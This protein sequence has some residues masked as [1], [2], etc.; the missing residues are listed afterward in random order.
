MKSSG[1]L[2]VAGLFA[3]ACPNVIAQ[4]GVA[5]SDPSQP[6]AGA[7]AIASPVPPAYPQDASPPSMPSSGGYRPQTQSGSGDEGPVRLE[8][9]PRPGRGA[10]PPPA[11]M[12]KLAA[13]TENGVTYL[14]GGI[15]QDEAN[16]MKQAARDYDLM[17]T[18]A[19]RDGSYLADVNV[20]IADAQDKSLLKTSCNAPIM[21]IDLGKSGIY[22]VR[23]E[24][25]GNTV[26]KSVQVK[27]REQGKSVV[28]VWPLDTV[29]GLAEERPQP[30]LREQ[31][32]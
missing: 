6:A 2:I 5:Q 12:S 19:A 25:G 26:S 4:S 23:A 20:D 1:V 22:R 11:P 28:L 21:L 29:R 14:C 3:C 8:A 13:R 16:D 10:M 17:L 15:G 9:R 32:R 30:A 27:P 7:A 18:F 31:T 24:T